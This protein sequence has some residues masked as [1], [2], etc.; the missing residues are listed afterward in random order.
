MDEEILDKLKLGAGVLFF[1]AIAFVIFQNASLVKDLAQGYGWFGLFVAS[2]IANATVFL[3]MPID[4]VVLAINAQSASLTEVIFLAVVVGSGAAI[5]EMS[6]YVAG[7]LGVKTAE[8]IKEKE[9]DKIKE[10]RRR[11]ESAGMGFIFLIAIIPFPFDIIGITAGFI[12]YNPQKFFI[13][14][15]A[16]KICRYIILGIAAYY[17]FAYIKE[18]NLI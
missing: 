7:L 1:A 5:G 13:A 17:G 16:G 8:Q 6:A 10:V 4:L 12:K 15:L 11:I 3:P 14:A 9:F 2:I 18:F